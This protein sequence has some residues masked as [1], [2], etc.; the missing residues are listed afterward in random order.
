MTK[1]LL[2]FFVCNIISCNSPAPTQKEKEKI[3]DHLASVQHDTIGIN[4]AKGQI[5]ELL[6]G[7]GQPFTWDTLIRSS[8][9]A[10]AVAEPILF[11]AFGKEQIISE[12]PYE[13]YLIDGYWFITGTMARGNEGGTF[14]IIFSAKDGKIIRLTHYK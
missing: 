10:V 1:I 5:K 3:V 13:T 4:Y 14:E 11:D 6:K 12:K 9:T 7:G 8:E 2:P